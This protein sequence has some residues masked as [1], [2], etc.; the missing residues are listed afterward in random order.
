MK[1]VQRKLLKERRN[2]LSKEEV[3]QYSHIICEKLKPYLK[4]TCAL[5][6]AYGNEVLLDEL[7]PLCKCV[8]PIV[9]DET[10]MHFVYYDDALQYQQGA[11]DI[12]EPLSNHYCDA[13]D[14]DVIIVP[15]VGFDEQLHRIGH[16]KG[17]Y[18]RYL[19]QCNALKIG[20]GYEIQ[21][22][23]TIIVDEHDIPLDMMISEKQIYQLKKCRE[24]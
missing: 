13:K 18:D 23:D 2:S 22:L 5:Y 16:G 8:L 12:R 3:L 24:S 14:I 9:D 6:C 10:K 7:F 17:Y 4:G 15:L 11:Y 1:Q 20:V 19:Q 21:K